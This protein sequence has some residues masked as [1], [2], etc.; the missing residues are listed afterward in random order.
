MEALIMLG[1][2]MLAP[3][4]LEIGVILWQLIKRS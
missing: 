3:V 2:L 1:F 4:W